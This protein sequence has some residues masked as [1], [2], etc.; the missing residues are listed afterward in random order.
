MTKPHIFNLN[1]DP[2]LSGR[3]IHILKPGATTIGNRKGVESDITM[4][5]PR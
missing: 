2:Q 3:I 1:Q 4:I 5:G